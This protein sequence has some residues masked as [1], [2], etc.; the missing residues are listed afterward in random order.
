[1]GHRKE[2]QHKEI[3][4]QLDATTQ[5]V[6]MW[7]HRAKQKLRRLLVERGIVGEVKL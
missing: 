1:L 4:D 5:E 7:L 3:A 6:A 2:L